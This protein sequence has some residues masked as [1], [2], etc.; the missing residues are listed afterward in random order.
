M[1]ARPAGRPDGS[2]PGAIRPTTPG[3][4]VLAACVGLL[5]G[6]A[7]RPLALYAGA[8]APR[9]SWLQVG[10]VFFVAAAIAGTAF[11]TWR[12]LQVN[13]SWLEPHRAVNRLVMA[14]SCVLVGALLAGGY[15]GTLVSWLG[16]AGESTGGNILRAGCAGVA[17]LVMVVASIWLE[18]ACRVHDDEDADLA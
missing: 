4:P 10:V 5:A 16:V 15:T 1:S 9:V 3:P 6:W 14:K 8:D 7:L 18:R 11:V 13:R 12:E 2:G 17:A